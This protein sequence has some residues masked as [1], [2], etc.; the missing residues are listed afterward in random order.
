MSNLIERNGL[1]ISPVLY[2]FVEREALPGTGLAPDIFWAGFAKLAHE[3]A[4]RNRALLAERDRLQAAI[5]DWHRSPKSR[6]LDAEAYTAFLKEI[7]YLEP[8]GPDFRSPPPMSIPKS[9]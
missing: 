2:D 3:L 4:P 1:Q 9:P 5:N 6:P 8:E 7:G